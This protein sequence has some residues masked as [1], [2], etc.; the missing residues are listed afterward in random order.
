MGSIVYGM[1][2]HVKH[3]PLNNL[4]QHT[5]IQIIVMVVHH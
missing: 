3:Y 1:V 2:L 5:L 4:V